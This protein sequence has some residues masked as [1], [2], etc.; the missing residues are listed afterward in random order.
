V[1]DLFNQCQNLGSCK[2][3]KNAVLDL[4][5]SKDAAN[6]FTASAD[7]SAVMWDTYDF[8][9][10]RTFRGHESHVNS[11]SVSA[12]SVVTGSDDC[13]VKLWDTRVRKHTASFNV[14]YQVTA[15]VQTGLSVF[16]GGVDNTIRSL[17]LRSN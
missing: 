12:Y 16:F 11:I 14:G 5:W 13:T 1:W 3:H 10:V 17:N 8:A 9:R 6:L 15:V 4:Q 2:G 7:K